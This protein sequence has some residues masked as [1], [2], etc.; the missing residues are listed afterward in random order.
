M[1]EL[2]RLQV[3]LLLAVARPGRVI[4]TTTG[5]DLWLTGREHSRANPMRCDRDIAVLVGA[6]LAVHPG[7]AG[8]YRLTAAGEEFVRTHRPA[9]PAPRTPPNGGD[10]A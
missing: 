7:P 1:I 4:H 8:P 5:V 9:P 2:N 6:G 3:R 10:P